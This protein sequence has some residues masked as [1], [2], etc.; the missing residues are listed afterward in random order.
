MSLPLMNAREMA[1]A[2]SG[3]LNCIAALADESRGLDAAAPAVLDG[4]REALEGIRAGKVVTSMEVEQGQLEGVAQLRS[5]VA[6]WAQSGVRPDGL[7]A[8]ARAVFAAVSGRKIE[9]MGAGP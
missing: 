1:Q 4:L 2:V 3:G 7:T 5:L 9:E 6:E 8:S